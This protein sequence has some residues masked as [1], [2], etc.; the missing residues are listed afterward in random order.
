MDLL[1]TFLACAIRFRLKIVIVYSP[2]YRNVAADALTRYM[3]DQIDERAEEQG[4]PW[5]A[6]PD[7]WAEFCAFITPDNL[8]R[9]L[10]PIC[11]APRSD[12][13]LHAAEW[14]PR[15]Y[16][17]LYS[18]GEFWIEAAQARARRPFGD[19]IPNGE[20]VPVWGPSLGA[21][22][23]CGPVKTDHVIRDFTYFASTRKFD[24]WVLALSHH[25]DISEQD[26]P[27]GTATGPVESA[28]LG[29]V[30]ACRWEVL[31]HG[32]LIAPEFDP[33]HGWSPLDT[34]GLR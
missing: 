11:F 10:A 24:Y 5:I 31:I 12:L 23:V 25:I 22:L 8:S 29:D 34:T 18:L 14:G 20:W 2:T 33:G 16:Q 1:E 4:P 30:S 3:A 15:S 27:H 19:G 7:I 13:C 26:A 6:T 17:A 9:D 32:D 21:V 28:L